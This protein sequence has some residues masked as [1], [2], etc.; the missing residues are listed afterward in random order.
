MN[1]ETEEPKEEKVEE[2]FPEGFYLGEVVTG[3]ENVIAFDGK[4]INEQELLVQVA[5]AVKKAGLMK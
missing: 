4:T 5:N 3:K 2:K 1:K